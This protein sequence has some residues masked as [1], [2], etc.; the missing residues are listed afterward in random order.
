MHEVGRGVDWHDDGGQ[1]LIADM[2]GWPRQLQWADPGGV[3]DAAAD[4]CGY[5]QPLGQC[6]GAG[7]STVLGAAGKWR[8]VVRGVT[9]KRLEGWTDTAV[10]ARRGL[11]ADMEG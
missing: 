4:V 8:I 11:A 6:G 10:V 9:C 3:F 7:S 2:E 5:V 1:G